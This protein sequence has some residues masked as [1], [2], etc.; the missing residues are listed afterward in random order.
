MQ[1][2]HGGFVRVMNKNGTENVYRG[3]SMENWYQI[4]AQGW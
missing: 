4:V 2:P 3:V 1:P